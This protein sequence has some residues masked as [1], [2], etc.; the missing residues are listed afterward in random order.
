MLRVL[1][2]NERVVDPSAGDIR[3]EY[4]PEYKRYRGVDVRGDLERAVG[5][6]IEGV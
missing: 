6:W 2:S 5:A 1:Y 3:S 4:Q